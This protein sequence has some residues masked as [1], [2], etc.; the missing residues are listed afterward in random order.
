MTGG[1]VDNP[2]TV[3]TGVRRAQ[4]GV[5]VHTAGRVHGDVTVCTVT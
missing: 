1:Q 4:V 2:A 3:H 5:T